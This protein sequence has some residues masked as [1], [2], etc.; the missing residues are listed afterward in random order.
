MTLLGVSPDAKDGDDSR[1]LPKPPPVMSDYVSVR[2]LHDVKGKS[3]RFAQDLKAPGGNKEWE[4]EV[5]SDR[6]GPATLSWPNLSR[7]PKTVN[8]KLTDKV[9]GRSTSLRGTS[10]TVVNLSA[11]VKSRFVLTASRGTSRPLTFTNVRFQSEGRGPSGSNY[12]VSFK[13]T[14]DAQVEARIMTLAGKT[15]NSLAGGRAVTANNVT[16]LLW[17]GRSQDGNRLPAGSYVLELRG[18]DENNEVVSVKRPI[19]ML[20]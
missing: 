19:T 17:N 7:L 6:T 12:S 20:R 15:V 2:I 11:N 8:L 1:D 9:T 16:R 5:V 18:R 10:S 4:I 14:A 3:R 13:S